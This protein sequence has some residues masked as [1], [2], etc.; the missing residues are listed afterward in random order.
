[1]L[2]R[3]PTFQEVVAGIIAIIVILTIAALLATQSAVPAELWAMATYLLGIVT[4][5]NIPS[6]GQRA[7]ES[8]LQDMLD[9]HSDALVKLAEAIPPK[10]VAP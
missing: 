8:A 1:M 4:G 6:P 9:K 7:K 10:P 3:K 5:V 2:D